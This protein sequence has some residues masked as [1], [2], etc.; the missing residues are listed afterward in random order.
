MSRIC[1]RSWCRLCD[2]GRMTP[3]V[4]L[5]DCRRNRKAM[6]LRNQSR[7]CGEYEALYCARG[8]YGAARPPFGHPG[9]QLHCRIVDRQAWSRQAPSAATT[10]RTPVAKAVDPF[11]TAQAQRPSQGWRRWLRCASIEAPHGPSRCL[12]PFSV[13]IPSFRL[14]S[15]SGSNRPWASAAR[16]W[17]RLPPASAGLAAPHGRLTFSLP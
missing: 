14:G 2:P 13:S 11:V 15:R 7:Y 9:C 4:L 8:F 10:L 12:A 3:M 5:R 1:R 16:Q 17:H 6:V